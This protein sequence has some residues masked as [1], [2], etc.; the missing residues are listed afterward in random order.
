MN[1][2]RGDV[3][4]AFVPFIGS[5]GGKLR[6]ALIVQSDH[7]NGRL[8]ET[9]IAAITSNVTRVREKSQLLI[10]IRRRM[11]LPP[12]CFTIPRFVANV[13]IPFCKRM[14]GAI[15]VSCQAS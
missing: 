1:V 7:I 14:C 11:A 10:D 2:K 3:V 12:G 8:N 5:P 4:L 13:Y 15:S 6:P 9:I